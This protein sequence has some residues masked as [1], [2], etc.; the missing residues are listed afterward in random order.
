MT[1][2]T[3]VDLDDLVDP[4][5]QLSKIIHV[6]IVETMLTITLEW[7]DDIFSIS[8]YFSGCPAG[9]LE[10]SKRGPNLARL[11]CVSTEGELGNY[12]PFVFRMP[13]CLCTSLSEHLLS[14]TAQE[15]LH[16]HSSALENEKH[17]S[18]YWQ[19]SLAPQYQ[20]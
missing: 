19:S 2:F 14:K 12:K 13:Q 11:K 1:I 8:N 16:Q 7:P 17:L 6:N 10:M 3:I 20:M 9:W 4:S 5:D 15:E 18:K